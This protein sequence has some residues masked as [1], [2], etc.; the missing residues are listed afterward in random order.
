MRRQCVSYSP[1][2]DSWL[3]GAI[4]YT[5]SEEANQELLFRI[6]EAW[7][8]C[9]IISS[10]MERGGL[11]NF[12]Q[13]F[14]DVGCLYSNSGEQLFALMPLLGQTILLPPEASKSMEISSFVSYRKAF[15]ERVDIPFGADGQAILAYA[16]Q[17]AGVIKQLAYRSAKEAIVSHEDLAL[18]LFKREKGVLWGILFAE[19]LLESAI[20]TAFNKQGL[21]FVPN[22]IELASTTPLSRTDFD[23]ATT[24]YMPYSDLLKTWFSNEDGSLHSGDPLTHPVF[25]E[26]VLVNAG[27]HEAQAFFADLAT[28]ECASLN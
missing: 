9:S 20:F 11:R 15:R 21:I 25:G 27:S 7:N 26:G 2:I 24:Q 17:Y 10:I 6:A 12:A 22:K 13:K 3:E 5:A 23:G 28:K 16:Q 4:L 19:S 1:L 14:E 8:V 18:D